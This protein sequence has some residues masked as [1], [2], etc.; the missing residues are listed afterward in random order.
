MSFKLRDKV[1]AVTGASSGIGLAT[2]KAF[3]REGARVAIGARS[4]EK[5]EALAAEL[6][7]QGAQVFARPLDVAD[8]LSVTRFFERLLAEWGY[9]DVLVNNAG[10]GL[11]API[12]ELSVELFDRAVQVNLYGALRCI[13]AVLPVMRARSRGQIINVSDAAGKR[14][15]PYLGGYG[16]TKSALNSLTEALRVEVADEGID[17]ILVCPG[18]VE[19]GLGEKAFSSRKDRPRLQVRG[20]SPERVAAAIVQ[21]S[22]RRRREVLLSAG[23]RALVTANVVTP[24]LLDRA[25]GTVARRVVGK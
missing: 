22:K 15:L 19:T 25:L 4:Q 11:F 23:G 24:R 9:C 13:R 10:V 20:M 5:I 2:A 21:A 18:V 1:V 14:A 7:G 16:A 12:A 17:V 3:A 8:E 6:T